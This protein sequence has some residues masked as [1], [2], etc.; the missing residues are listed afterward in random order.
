MRACACALDLLRRKPPQAPN[1]PAAS[2]AAAAWH[3]TPCARW[4]RESCATCRPLLKTPG[5]L[6]VVDVLPL[7]LLLLA[8]RPADALCSGAELVGVVAGTLLDPVAARL[9]AASWRGGGRST[10]ARPRPAT[11]CAIVVGGVIGRP[12][13]CGI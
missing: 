9:A 3:T 11:T 6:P 1:S 7:L 12:V 8:P 4:R 2:E 10:G 13:E 5:R